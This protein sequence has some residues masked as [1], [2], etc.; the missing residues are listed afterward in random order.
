MFGF[1]VEGIGL[2][3]VGLF[4]ALFGLYI[5]IA[6]LIPY[7]NTTESVSDEVLGRVLIEIPI[8]VALRLIGRLSDLF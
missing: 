3:L 8:R 5:I 4:S 1:K 7:K 2:S 6:S